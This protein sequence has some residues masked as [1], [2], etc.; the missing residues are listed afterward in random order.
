VGSYVF[1]ILVVIALGGLIA[2]RLREMR[3]EAAAAPPVRHET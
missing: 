3:R 2:Y 1:V